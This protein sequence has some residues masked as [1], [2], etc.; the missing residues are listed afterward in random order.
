MLPPDRSEAVDPPITILPLAT[1]RVC[2]PITTLV[3]GSVCVPTTKEPPGSF[4]M[5][6]VCVPMTMLLPPEMTETVCPPT[7]VCP[8]GAMETVRVWVPSTSS[9]VPDTV[10][11]MPFRI[12]LTI[13]PAGGDDWVGEARFAVKLTVTPL[14]TTAAPELPAERVVPSRR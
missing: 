11:P 14:M 10:M 2:V 3:P 9:C 8:P 5:G 7:T 6:N 12:A 4:E 13:A 1:P